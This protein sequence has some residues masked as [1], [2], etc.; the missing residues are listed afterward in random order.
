MMT[1]IIEY[2]PSLVAGCVGAANQVDGAYRL[3]FVGSS[4]L[5]TAAEIL[6]ATKVARI[7]ASRAECSRRI[8]ERY[9]AGRQL[10]ALA[11]LARLP[12]AGHDEGLDC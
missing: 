1:Q 11:G 4:R 10:S 3:D 7:A 8:F 9:P 5:A 2:L 12:I 6:A